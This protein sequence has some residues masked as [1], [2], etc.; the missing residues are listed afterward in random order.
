MIRFYLQTKF[1]YP[2][3]LGLDWLYMRTFSDFE[4]IQNDPRTAIVHFYLQ[5]RIKL[6]RQLN[7]IYNCETF[8]LWLPIFARPFPLS[9]LLCAWM[10]RPRVYFPRNKR[11]YAWLLSTFNLKS[12]GFGAF[13]VSAPELWIKLPDDIRF[14]DNLNLFKR[15]LK[16][17]LF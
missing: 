5:S 15:K 8:A 14:C 10:V 1:S 7:E 4:D 11:H 3:I 9:V 17:Y 12:Y 13:A 2:K 6:S 16:T